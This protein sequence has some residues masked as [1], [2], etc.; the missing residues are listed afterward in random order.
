MNIEVIDSSNLKNRL[1]QIAGIHA[2]AYSD[3]HFTSSFSL[4][5]LIEYNLR[6]I[7]ASTLSVVAMED[8]EVLGFIISGEKVSAGVSKFINENRGWLMLQLLRS[9][10]ILFAKILAMIQARFAPVQPS[11]AKFR[12]LTIAIKPGIQ[13][14]G[15]GKEMLYFFERELLKIGVSCYG[16][17]VRNKNSR[18]IKFYERHNF[19]KEKEYIDA[20]YYL[21][22]IGK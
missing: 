5:K 4:E 18:A 17:S 9:P 10:R 22:K 14:K 6:L 12:L 16:L 15:V 21:K 20:S 13:S 1:E 7:E 11:E 8:D 3:D 2:L 19:I